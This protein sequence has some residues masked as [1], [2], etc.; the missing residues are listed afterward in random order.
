MWSPLQDNLLSFPSSQKPDLL[1]WVSFTLFSLLFSLLVDKD[2][3]DESNLCE[4]WSTSYDQEILTLSLRSFWFIIF[5]TGFELFFLPYLF[6][7]VGFCAS[8]VYYLNHQQKRWWNQ[9]ILGHLLTLYDVVLCMRKIF[10]SDHFMICNF[11]NIYDLS[12]ATL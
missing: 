9:K 10:V 6:F 12:S 2:E 4:W 8:W 11:W 7:F 3:D 5:L 1:N